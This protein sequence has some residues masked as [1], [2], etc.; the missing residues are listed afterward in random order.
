MVKERVFKLSMPTIRVAVRPI[1]RLAPGR[2]VQHPPAHAL[3]GLACRLPHLACRRSHVYA[4]LAAA[5]FIS[6]LDYLAEIDWSEAPQVK[7]WY[8][9][10]K[11]GRPSVRFWSSASGR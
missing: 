5:A 1:P 3:S 10:I 8:Q 7:E 9:R 6:I 11:S 2:P 4:D